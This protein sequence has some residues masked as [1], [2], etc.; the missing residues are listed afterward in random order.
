[1][2]PLSPL[3]H[4]VT[5]ALPGPIAKGPAT[6]GW[7]ARRSAERQ[8]S[9]LGRGLFPGRV[10]RDDSACSDRGCVGVAACTE[11]CLRRLPAIHFNLPVDSRGKMSGIVTFSKWYSLAVDPLL[12]V[13]GEDER[14]L[15]TNLQ[16]WLL[17]NGSRKI[18]T[19]LTNIVRKVS[20]DWPV[21]VP[22]SLS[23]VTL[24]LLRKTSGD[25]PIA[26]HV[27]EAEEALLSHPAQWLWA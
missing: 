26:W 17:G 22:W 20:Q 27:R 7:L 6:S 9:G 11:H 4:G 1:M 3:P 23:K 12:L 21:V 25:H 2:P 19:C 24:F 13:F 15:Q 5:S 16:F 18:Q 10:A 14:A 8:C